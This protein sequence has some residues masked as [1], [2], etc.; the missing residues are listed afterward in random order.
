[1]RAPAGGGHAAAG[2][3]PF[4]SLGRHWRAASAAPGG[5]QC[6]YAPPHPPP[7]QCAGV[8]AGHGGAP[9]GR[10][11]WGAAPRRRSP[12]SRPSR[13]GMRAGAERQQQ[14]RN[15]RRPPPQPQHLHPD[16][17][18]QQQRQHQR[19]RQRRAAGGRASKQ[20]WQ[21][22]ASRVPAC[23]RRAQRCAGRSGCRACRR[24]AARAPPWR[25]THSAAPTKR[26]RG[27]THSAGRR[28]RS[29]AGQQPAI[30]WREAAA[31]L[32]GAAGHLPFQ[33]PVAH[34]A[35]Q[36][37]G[38]AGP[39]AQA[40]A[41]RDQGS[42]VHEAWGWRRG[43]SSVTGLGGQGPARTHCCCCCCC[44]RYAAGAWDWRWLAFFS[45]Q[46]PIITVETLL[47]RWWRA[48]SLPPPP[49]ALSVFLTNFL[50]IVVR[51]GAYQHCCMHALLLLLQL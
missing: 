3:L 10:P 21:R 32:P 43:G 33:W 39:R 42:R 19:R 35:V 45:L 40:S 6:S 20:A 25:R 47:R 27:C 18:Q 51:R 1:M 50:L 16:H 41:L 26:W 14:R 22:A 13:Q 44:C 4:V 49:R 17:Q 29:S 8:R 37:G 46:G 23:V 31:A 28:G 2:A 34:A 38:P 5:C 15:A 9:A 11:C 48:R 7:L 30:Q 24:A 12:A 36:V